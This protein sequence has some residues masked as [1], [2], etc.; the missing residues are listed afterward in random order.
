MVVRCLQSKC[1]NSYIFSSNTN[2]FIKFFISLGYL[3]KYSGIIPGSG[4][5]N[6]SGVLRGSNRMPGFKLELATDKASSLP[7]AWY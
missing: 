6:T 1:L 4:S 2:S 3:Q 7:I 5:G